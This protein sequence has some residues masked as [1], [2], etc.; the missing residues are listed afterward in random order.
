MIVW[1]SMEEAVYVQETVVSETGGSIG[2]RDQGALEASLFR[3][4]HTFGGADLFPSLEEKVAA[5]I[6]GII[7]SHPFIDG[8]KRTGIRLGL[9]V[10]LE[11]GRKLDLEAVDDDA[12]EETAV[13]VACGQL[14][15]EGLARW[16]GRIFL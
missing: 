16:L 9:D 11:N 13:A 15:V 12:V 4:L 10:M 6:H 2:V 7:T 3:P 14:G 5:L 1:P 8:N